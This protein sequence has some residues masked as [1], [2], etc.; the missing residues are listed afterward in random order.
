MDADQI[1]IFNWLTERRQHI[2][3][4]L[5]DPSVSGFRNSA[6][7]KYSDQAH[8]VSELLQNADDAGATE[9]R[10]EL[11]ANELI[12]AHNGTRRFSLS[13]PDHEAE[14]RQ[15]GQ[16]GDINAITSMGS[17]N[18]NP[19]DTIGR[20]GIGFK[21]VFKYTNTPY[22]Y[23]DTLAF[24]IE[25]LVVPVLLHG[26]Y[27]GRRPGETLFLLPFNRPQ[28]PASTAVSDIA[29]RLRSLVYPTLFLRHLRRIEY[30]YG[31]Q[32]GF[33]RS[34][35]KASR[36]LGTLTFAEIS[37]SAEPQVQHS[38]LLFFER[39][40][41]DGHRLAVA[42]VTDGE[43]HLVPTDLPAFSYFPTKE[44]TGLHFL[45]HAPFLLNDSREGIL[46]G[47]PHNRQMIDGLAALAADSLAA[48]VQSDTG[49]TYI[50]DGIFAIIPYDPATF[51]PPEHLHES[52]RISFLPFYQA[53]HDKFLT[54]PII[55]TR[56]PGEY[57]TTRQA[58]WATDR[59]LP[60]LFSDE[61]LALLTGVAD[62]HW[63]FTRTGFISQGS[64]LAIV[65]F[66][67]TIVAKNYS[68]TALLQLLTPAFI[69]QQSLK[70]LHRLYAFIRQSASRMK[71]A[72][73]LPILLGLD[74]KPVVPFDAAGEPQIFL[75]TSDL[76]SGYPTVYP[77][78][79]REPDTRQFLKQLGLRQPSL[80]DEIFQRILPRCAG[81][82]Q[83]DTRLY[84]R[85]FV[86]YFREV[87]LPQRRKLINA[88]AKVRWLY[89]PAR[90]DAGKSV[91][92][93]AASR[94]AYMATPE[95]V[96]YFAGDDEAILIQPDEYAELAGA[97]GRGG[98]LDRFLAAVAI[99]DQ[100]PRLQ[101]HVLSPDELDARGLSIPPH[102]QQTRRPGDTIYGVEI[103]LDGYR[104]LLRR[105]EKARN[106]L[107]LSQ[108]L[109]CLLGR[110][111]AAHRFH[112][113][114]GR[115]FHAAL[116]Y[117]REAAGTR[118]LSQPF[119]D[120]CLTALR[121]T[122]WLVNRTGS[123]VAPSQTSIEM[124]AD[125]YDAAEPAHTALLELLGL[126]HATPEQLCDQL[127][128]R[129]EQQQA[130]GWDSWEIILLLHMMHEQREYDG[131]Q[132]DLQARLLAQRL[133]GYHRRTYAG[134]DSPL[135]QDPVAALTE[136]IFSL[137]LL[138]RG[139]SP[140]AAGVSPLAQ[141]LY[142]LSQSD[143]DMFARLTRAAAHRI[144]AD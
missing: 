113:T 130:D 35:I 75:P 8:F 17:S 62:A 43:G 12:F 129:Y 80:A 38:D 22:I 141:E 81:D 58:F 41:N 2:A 46:A 89:Y 24:R 134:S 84:I 45:I 116:I 30:T 123:L 87:G 60:L 97:D 5:E 99:E 140:A 119:P 49:H 91:P 133:A 44:K 78:L 82:G 32:Q 36:D 66:I 55:P 18:K 56:T 4:I 67:V 120:A 100:H 104:N 111:I 59:M 16:R 114:P 13:D 117:R 131:T 125:G 57:V 11:R 110:A 70:W 23:D 109:W 28:M 54:A 92:G 33:Y 1:N 39:Q 14:S 102:W 25:R 69:A 20:F 77:G 40:T 48:L 126:G 142:E 74:K 27:P 139:E 83:L 31:A 85:K 105:L 51:T 115:I 19:K 98:A 72:R 64:S 132:W 73:S 50:D 7:E 122:P 90:D 108:L 3:D 124:L 136:A 118:P 135:L 106:P 65:R 112:D 93:R 86:R 76:A 42:C 6:I 47:E 37:Y 63:V 101:Q 53:I 21:S 127:I 121:E 88:L 107:P 144:A 34:D 137:H 94:D 143:P 138:A 15:A 26:D 79:W 68:D 52:A 71:L 29:A 128:R 95:L 10:F 96:E 103:E 9:A 61:Q